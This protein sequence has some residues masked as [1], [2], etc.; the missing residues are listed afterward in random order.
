MHIWPLGLSTSVSQGACTRVAP[1]GMVW[2]LQVL[3]MR[4]HDA[5]FGH[6]FLCTRWGYSCM[7]EPPV[8]CLHVP[9]MPL[10]VR[11]RPS[12]PSQ[13]RVLGSCQL[14]PEHFCFDPPALNY[15]VLPPMSWFVSHTLLCLVPF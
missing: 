7:P 8:C 15:S 11:V 12:H 6:G 9:G 2:L 13:S 1:T 14:A 3:P 10:C 4:N 5:G